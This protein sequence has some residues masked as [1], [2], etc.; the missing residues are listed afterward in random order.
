MIK[1]QQQENTKQSL[2]AYLSQ[3]QGGKKNISA[4][5]I[6]ELYKKKY[7]YTQIQKGFLYTE[8]ANT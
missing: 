1:V 5:N 7:I 3:L 4:S 8:K 6:T 2:C